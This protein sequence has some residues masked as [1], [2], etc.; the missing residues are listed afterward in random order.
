MD[1]LEILSRIAHIQEIIKFR[2]SNAGE[3]MT[4]WAR[5]LD[6]AEKELIKL[7]SDIERGRGTE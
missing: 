1:V 7:Y 6:E 2:R 5:Q 3:Y 4:V